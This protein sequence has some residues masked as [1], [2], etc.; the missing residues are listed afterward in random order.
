MKPTGQDFDRLAHRHRDAVLRQMIRACG[1]RDDA[2]DV[3]VESLL[4][5]FRAKDSVRDPEAF[6]VWLARIAHRACS[7]VKR[8]EALEPILLPE[9]LD[10][11]APP[12]DT[13]TKQCLMQAMA[14]LPDPLRRVVELRDLEGLGTTEAAQSLGIGE[15]ALKSRLHRARAR[16]RAALDESLARPT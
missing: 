12:P 6:G 8:R 11:A 3:L 15:G 7:R 1:N 2:E 16:L 14:E 13:E 9:A 10:P 5:A 4:A